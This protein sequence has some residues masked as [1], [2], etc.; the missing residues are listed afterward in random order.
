MRALALALLLSAGPAG[1]ATIVIDFEEEAVGT[2]TGSFIS[3]EHPGVTLSEISGSFGQLIVLDFYLGTRA[4]VVGE[5]GGTLILDFAMPVTAVSMDFGGDWIEDGSP[6]RLR[7][8][9]GGVLVSMAELDANHNG[10]ID[11]TITLVPSVAIDR[12]TFGMSQLGP[13]DKLSA[14]VDNISLTVP[15]PSVAALLLLALV[16]GGVVHVVFPAPHQR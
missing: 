11:Q 7:G 8:Y 3:V 4:L 1:A 6:A 13:D 16:V 15:E 10:L 14:L 9:A 12:V 2:R 5:E